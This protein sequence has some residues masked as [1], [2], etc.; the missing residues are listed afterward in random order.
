MKFSKRNPLIRNNMEEF[1]AVIGSLGDEIKEQNLDEIN[2]GTGQICSAISVS[3]S[4]AEF[5]MATIDW[6]TKLIGCGGVIT[7]TVECLC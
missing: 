7:V 1:N 5:S 6:I 4:I 3:V 2:G